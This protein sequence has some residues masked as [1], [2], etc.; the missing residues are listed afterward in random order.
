[1][2]IIDS[3]KSLFSPNRQVNNGRVKDM[4]MPMWS[5]P[6]RRNS[7]AWMELYMKSPRMSPIHKIATDTAT[8][9]YKLQVKNTKPTKIIED[10][11]LLKLLKNPCS[12]KEI[13]GYTL[14]YLTQVYRDLPSGEAFWLIE[15]N[16]LGV[17]SE[18]WI[19]PPHWVDTTP[20]KDIPYFK[21]LPHGNT[22]N[23]TIFAEPRDVIWFKEPNVVEPYA[24]GRGRSEAI[25][26]EMETDEYM[27]KYQK[28][29]FYNNAQPPIVIQAPGADE[30]TV[31]RLQEQFMQ[32]NGG[33]SNAGKP[34]V[35]NWDSK[36]TVL[37]ETQKEMDFSQSRKDLRDACNQFWNMPPEL[38][39]ILENSNRSTIDAADFIYTK[40][41]LSQKLKSFDDV[42]NS[43]LAPQFDERIELIHDKVVPNDV[44]FELRKATEGLKYGGVTVDEWRRANGWEDLKDNKGN[45]LYTPLNMMPTD[46]NGESIIDNYTTQD[47]EGKILKGMSEKR[48]TVIWKNFDKGAT[49]Y[50]RRLENE[51]K[52]FF[53]KQQDKITKKLT[54][55]SNKLNKADELHKDEF[56]EEEFWMLENDEL[57]V[58]LQLYWLLTGQEGFVIANNLY[59]LNLQ[60]DSVQPELTTWIRTSGLDRVIGINDT[61]RNQLRESLAEGIAAGESNAALRDRVSSI[62]NEAKG[63]RATKIARTETM[64]SLNV[65]AYNAYKQA[66]FKKKEWLSCRDKRVRDS[67]VKIDGEIVGINEKFSNGLLHPH[68]EGPASEVINCRCTLVIPDE[69]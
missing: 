2:K 4:M 41:V 35:T 20:T 30:A 5:M 60:L 15:R 66:G 55:K 68:A 18:L 3:I 58:I 12:N 69:E 27:A 33:I 24:R 53:Q 51:L 56:E 34:F 1:L 26:D 57:I 38:F 61:T 21:I 45:I 7:A 37:K 43:Q 16:G 46:L 10:H 62:Y 32:R 65:G 67:H 47:S 52:K 11:V 63:S 48:K 13:T 17:P 28:M 14:L 22:S 39:G 42:I 8:A 25:G 59:D 31:S 23:Q 44:D 50:E 9:T 49:K 64:T 29:F 36:I 6:P 40:N 54:N 19:I